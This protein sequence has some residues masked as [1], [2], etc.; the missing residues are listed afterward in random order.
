MDGEHTILLAMCVR[1]SKHV[2]NRPGKNKNLLSYRKTK[3][4]G[5]KPVCK[6][7]RQQGRESEVSTSSPMHIHISCSHCL[8]Q[9]SWTKNPVRKPRTEQH[10]EAMRKKMHAFKSYALQLEVLVE[11]CKREHGQGLDIGS[12]GLLSRPQEMDF[13]ED[14]DSEDC[15]YEIDEEPASDIDDPV[16]EIFGSAPI[17]KVCCLTSYNYS[18][19]MS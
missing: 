1:E 12:S 2:C 16:D 4:D 9:C 6:P 10:F 7:C 13:M 19:I 11:N 8:L 15:E 17:L 5:I 14:S 18:R 3:C